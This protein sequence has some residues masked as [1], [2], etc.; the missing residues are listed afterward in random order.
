MKTFYPKGAEWRKWDLHFHTPSSYDY[1]DKSVTNDDLLKTLSENG[2]AVV[3]ITDHHKMDVKRIRELQEKGSEKGITVLPGIEFLSDARGSEPIHF[4]GI[5]S[6]NCK[7]DFVWGQIQNRTEIS[8]IVGEGKK[9]NEV[10]CDLADTTALLHELGGLVSI[11]SGSK[12][13]TVETITNSLK[14][15]MAQKTDIAKCVDIY[16]LGKAADQDGYREQVFPC[17]GKVLPMIICSDNHNS[18]KYQ[19]KANC[20][21]KADPSFE[22]LRQTVIEPDERV[23]I[24]DKPPLLD[25]VAKNR[26]K[27]IKELLLTQ[28]EGYD[29]RYGKWF[30]DVSLPLNR[31]LVAIIGNKG[32]G[33]SAVADVLALCSNY[34]PNDR[35]FSFLTSGKFKKNRLAQNF[36]AIMTWESDKLSQ[37]NL[38]GVPESTE[39]LDVK[40]IPQGQFER[41][42]NEIRTAEQFQR[43][44]ES[45]V[46]S[47]IPESERLGALS[48]SEL[49]KRTTSS[50]AQELE[51]LKSDVRDVNKDIISLERKATSSYR[52]EIEKKLAKKQEELKALVEPPPVSDP[53]EDPEKKAVNEEVNKNIAAL[54]KEI[55]QLLSAIKTAESEK[56]SALEALQK[57]KDVKSNIKQRKTE[58][59]R[60]ISDTELELAAFDI[61]IKKLITVETDFSRLEA[62]ILDKENCLTNAKI[63]LGEQGQDDS[64]QSFFDLL[65]IKEEKLKV[66]KSK[67]DAEQQH[68]QK[69]LADLE[70][71]SKDRSMIIGAPEKFDT[72]K[73]YEH[74]LKYL[75]ETL[76]AELENKYDDRR[77][78]VQSI[79]DK[80]QKVI[81]VYK[82]ARN[83]LEKIIQDN[84]ST[85]K[86]YRIKVDAALVKNSDFTFKFLSFIN[87]KRAGSFYSR[88]GG[89]TQVGRLSAEVDF[90]DK[91]SV[92]SFLDS[93][94]EALRHDKRDGLENESRSVAEQVKDI[95]GLYDYLFSLEFLENN[96]QLKQGD[97]DLEQLSP[98]ERGALLLVF[99]LLLDN[100]DIPLV[101]D[102]P[103]DNL[104]NHSVAT[105]L[106]PFIRAA[107]KRRQI[108]IVT[109]NPNLAV[110]SDAEQVIYVDLDKES[111][112]TFSTVSG[113]IEDKV[114]NE[115]IVNVLEGAMPAFN[116][117]KRKY[118]E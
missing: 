67:L 56:K 40:Y 69:Y 99:Y 45:V 22:G 41:L 27:Y 28:D 14:H 59:D 12:H 71:W 43:E 55:Q 73:Y 76:S 111:N 86:D 88:D 93:L 47:H 46:F 74:E 77:V 35:D 72:L 60:F 97:K 92:I 32:S 112:Y 19:L 4:I 116:M 100:S 17:I 81:A 21:L 105:I 83:R 3:A 68:F 107:K 108:I 65:A 95:A 51:Q 90:D 54:K 26:T 36:K 18:H 104:D 89:E 42:T 39:L 58:I 87:Q 8:K 110:V 25:R 50:V 2:V 98:G 20:W 94:V 13:G 80:K 84:Q 70:A 57:L 96:Y 66:E 79:F 38:G 15:T 10:Y 49:I 7:L 109:H 91:G 115:K 24:G 33:K 31:E 106:V 23:F 118:Y 103:E 64:E 75:N 30:K 114:V 52:A 44:I 78:V 9:A 5:F 29:E 82:D 62:L 16:E 6:E 102:Q 117:R 48:F 34:Q 85:L 61:D 63:K 53:N 101:I 37:M 113:S 1:D 11:H